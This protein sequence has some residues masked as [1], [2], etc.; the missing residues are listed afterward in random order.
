MSL[1]YSEFPVYI[2][3]A[4]GSI[5]P[6]VQRYVPATQASINYNT[7]HN[8][9][10]K[11][12]KTIDSSDQFNFSNALTADIS[13]DSFPASDFGI[14]QGK[15]KSISSKDREIIV[16]KT[17]PPSR[18]QDLSF[19][20]I[21]TDFIGSYSNAISVKFNIN[22]VVKNNVNTY[23]LQNLDYKLHYHL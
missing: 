6:E 4:G 9:N 2:G 8:P 13:I 3:G 21:K 16:S 18:L 22:E 5:P 19:V 20:D 11:L 15:V 14:I 12:G 23:S 7:N 1:P 10:R 17:I